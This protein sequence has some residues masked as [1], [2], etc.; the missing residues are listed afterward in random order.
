MGF[1]S[2]HAESS[3]TS[4]I[5]KVD[6]NEAGMENLSEGTRMSSDAALPKVYEVFHNII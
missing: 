6:K 3:S 5:S 2:Q 4:M 1:K